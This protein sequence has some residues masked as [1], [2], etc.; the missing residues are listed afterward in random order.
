MDHYI[1]IGICVFYDTDHRSQYVPDR[2]EAEEADAQNVWRQVGIL[3][4]H[5]TAHDYLLVPDDRHNGHT[6][7]YRDQAESQ[8]GCEC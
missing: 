3:P 8:D 1:W 5:T 4:G 6:L 7:G 2:R